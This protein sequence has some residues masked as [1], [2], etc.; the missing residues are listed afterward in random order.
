MI[1]DRID[2]IEKKIKESKEVK[3]NEKDELLNLLTNLRTEINDLSKTHKEHA[4][5]IVRFTEISAHEAT[6]KEKNP[7]LLNLS[8]EGLTSSI[9][10][11]EVSHP[12]LV[13]II[14]RISTMFYNIGI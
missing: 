4:D 11:F 12:T 2:K 1:Q 8:I 10:G 5:S 13:G 9:E 6:R 14:N 7:E 3:E